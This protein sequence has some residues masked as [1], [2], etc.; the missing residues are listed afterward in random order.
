MWY[1]QCC[2]RKCVLQSCCLHSLAVSMQRMWHIDGR[3]TCKRL[4]SQALSPYV[5]AEYSPAAAWMHAWHRIGR[6]AIQL[7]ARVAC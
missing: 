2:R 5:A 1:L 4:I 6:A 7:N 3:S